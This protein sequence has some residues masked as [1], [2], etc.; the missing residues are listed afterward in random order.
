MINKKVGYLVF[1]LI[2]IFALNISS[3]SAAEFRVG[4]D[5]GGIT[6]KPTE[7]IKNLYT[8]GNIL[9]IN[10]DIQKDLHAV[11]NVVTVN[12]NVENSVTVAGSTVNINGDV[13]GSVHV[14]GGSIIID[15]N[16][17]EDLFLAGGN[18]V[19]SDS[20]F[21][22]GDLYV[23]SGTLDMR[24]TVA[25]K[26][27]MAA[28]EMTFNGKAFESVVIEADNLTIGDSAE[29]MGNLQYK[30]SKPAKISEA[31]K[32]FGSI[33]F[34]QRTTKGVS[35][36]T[37]FGMFFGFLSFLFAIK[38]LTTI[39]IGLV[40][41]YL[42]RKITSSVVENSFKNFWAILGIG[43][44]GFVLTPILAI[45]LGITVIGLWLAA[46]VFVAYIFMIMLS[47]ALASIAFGSWL[48]KKYKKNK[49]YDIGWKQ[50]VF[51]S[52]AL[53]IVGFIPVVGW[54][55]CFV[56]FLVSLGSIYQLMYRAHIK[57]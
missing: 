47:S 16:I 3:V 33:D 50:V 48:V 1:G 56:F 14:A 8:A 45:L 7:I 37:F 15:G 53:A 20:A 54:L 38:L 26:V 11:G 2:A 40:L 35:K 9:L 6:T 23:G 36:T 42:F 12:G 5:G 4:K 18:V 49:N 51:G 57:K 13:G 10:S 24:G 27:K 43:F 41:V 29:I 46:L 44:A 39:A 25:G 22:G 34:D 19:V 55:T 32:I 17:T 30:S 28:G 31:A 21:I 52:I